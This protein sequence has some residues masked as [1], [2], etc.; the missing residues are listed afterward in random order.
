MRETLISYWEIFSAWDW[1]WQA[2]LVIAILTG[3]AIIISMIS[4]RSKKRMAG[5]SS[6]IQY[7]Y[8]LYGKYKKGVH[9]K[10]KKRVHGKYKKEEKTHQHHIIRHHVLP[11]DTIDSILATYQ[12][13]LAELVYYNNIQGNWE[14]H[15]GDIIVVKH[16]D[17]EQPHRRIPGIPS[18]THVQITE[19]FHDEAAKQYIEYDKK[20]KK[21]MIIM[22]TV[23]VGMFLVLMSPFV[24]MRPGTVRKTYLLDD[25]IYKQETLTRDRLYLEQVMY[26]LE[27]GD[28]IEQ[29]AQTMD[30]TS[31]SIY[32]LN[33]LTADDNIP[34]GQY[35]MIKQTEEQR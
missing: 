11:D 26:F 8:R 18:G 34:Y 22:V 12:I 28:T 2:M 23:F 4:L 29:I 25:K 19:V 33:E 32:Q 27:D 13:T 24:L 10:Y 6:I 30:T 14:I 1:R 15:A 20:K 35:I 9:G 31:E 21:T 7:G 5:K 3:L 17:Y 16:H